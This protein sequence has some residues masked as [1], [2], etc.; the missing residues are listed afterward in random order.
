[1]KKDTSHKGMDRRSFI[2]LSSGAVV[3]VSSNWF[4]PR[5]ALG[6]DEEIRLGGICAL[7]GPASTIGVEQARAIE[8]AVE[9]YNQKG[10]V[11]GRKIK[12]L[13]EDNESK[14]DVGLAKAR[15]LVERNKV[16]FLTGII[17]S[18]ISMGIQAYTKEKRILFVNS[19][20]GN[21]ALIQPPHCN[22][23]F[24]KAVYSF[25]LSC[26]AIRDAAKAIGPKWYFI[27]DNYSWG[28][29]CVEYFKKSI[30]LVKPDFESVGEDFPPFGE[31][32]YAPYLT[33]VMAA[34]PDGLAIA[35]FGAG[36]SRSIKQAKQ[37]GLKCHIHHQFWS[38]ID[39]RATGEAALGITGAS[40]FLNENP[41]I[42]RSQEFSDA[43]KAKYGDFPGTIGANG[44]NGV[45]VIMEA[46][47]AAGTFETEALIDT[48]ESMTYK[49][50]ILSPD[51]HF[52]KADH[53]PIT[54][55][56]TVEVVKDPKYKLGTKVL[57]YDPNP[58]AFVTPPDETGCD[59]HMKKT[60]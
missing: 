13:M 42:P 38:F 2:K 45:E 57:S 23:Y 21:D 18:S 50:S 41:N 8:L 16:D 60:G 33:K 32:N 40:D 29:G 6:A 51:Y 11:L 22:R 30:E 14:K 5:I 12:V 55:L 31:T 58:V 27:A 25:K 54:G 47:K 49:N 52:R 1:M 36:W 15:R 44:F 59:E 53:Q 37:M 4:L 7:S 24:F 35:V 10:G 9:M 28:K 26:L 19:G 46:A 39:G 3:A 56:Y 17:F 34:N 43:Y 20:S 48:M